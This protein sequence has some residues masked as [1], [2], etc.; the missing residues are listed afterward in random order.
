[1]IHFG[2]GSNLQMDYLLKMLPSAKFMMKAYIPNYEIRFNFWSKIQEAGISN[3]IHAPGKMVHGAM[4][5]VDEAEMRELDVK[6]GYYIGDYERRTFIAL[7]EDGKWYDTELYQV[8]DPQGPFKPA[9]NYVEGMLVGA[10][11]L[12]LAPEAIAAIEQF[13]QDSL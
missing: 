8:I 11:E 9:K 4:F 12:N 7:G 1:M 3:I 10:K 13:Y 5:E 6:P 2:Y